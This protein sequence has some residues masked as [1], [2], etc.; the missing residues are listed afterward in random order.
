MSAKRFVRN[1]LFGKHLTDTF[2][3]LHPRY[4]GI[5]GQ[6]TGQGFLERGQSQYDEDGLLVVQSNTYKLTL[7]GISWMKKGIVPIQYQGTWPPSNR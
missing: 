1:R 5:L 4:G 2:D 7:K 3:V 6:L